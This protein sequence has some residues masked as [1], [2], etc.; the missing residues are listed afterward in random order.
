MTDTDLDCIAAV[1]S[2]NRFFTTVM[3]FLDQGLLQS[4]YS[5]TEARVV[6]E[7]AQQPERDVTELRTTLDIDAGQLSRILARLDG[8]GLVERS[9]SS[10]DGRRHRA[11]LTAAGRDVFA[12]LDARSNRQAGELLGRL[13]DED[14]RRLVAALGTVRELLD[15]SATPSGYVIRGLHPGDLGWVVQRNGALYAQEYGW[16]QTYEAL[17]AR[18]V[19]DYGAEHDPRHEDAWIAEIDGRP[20]GSVF[21]MRADETT[22][23]LR[24]LLVEPSARGLGVGSRLVDECIRFARSAGY[25]SL[26]L[27]TNDVLTAARRIYERAGF[28]LVDEEAHHSFGQELVGQ[29]WRLELS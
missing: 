3:G 28:R 9:R 26:V 19:A 22:A 11:A 10:T 8:A 13:S 16:D 25:S 6:F 4:D 23:K 21:C 12:G 5:L 24:L 17:V 2:F 18:I 1:R 14:Q 29:N 15:D 27:W 20:A 7:L